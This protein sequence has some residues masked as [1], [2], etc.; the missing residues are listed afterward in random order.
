[1]LALLHY[2]KATLQKEHKCF[3]CAKNVSISITATVHKNDDGSQNCFRFCHAIAICV[4]EKSKMDWAITDFDTV[5]ICCLQLSNI[6]PQKYIDDLLAKSFKAL[7]V[8]D[9]GTKSVIFVHCVDT[10]IHHSSQHYMA[11]NLLGDLNDRA[12]KAES[13]L[14]IQNEAKSTPNNEMNNFESINSFNKK[15]LE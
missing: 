14:S 11:Q 10:F 9:N 4:L 15:K 2:V 5:K 1:M 12:F 8:Y 13:S 7:D 3:M 6:P